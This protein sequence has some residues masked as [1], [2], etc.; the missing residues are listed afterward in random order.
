M[1]KC[2]RCGEFVT[3]NYVRVF[4]LEGEDGPRVC[5]HCEDAV[6]EGTGVRLARR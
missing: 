6:R 3:E 5:P 4:A 2:L 1:A